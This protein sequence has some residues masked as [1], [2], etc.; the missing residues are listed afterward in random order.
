MAT[1][2]SA[3]S[4][5]ALLDEPD[6]SLQVYSLEN[7]NQ[8]ADEFW[9]EIADYVTKIEELYEDDKFPQ[10]KLTA[11]VASKVGF[12]GRPDMHALASELFELTFPNRNQVYYNLAE[13]DQSMHFALAAGELFDLSVKTEYVETIVCMCATV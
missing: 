5:L 1:L 13:F 2:T 7:L 4:L 12:F 8:L 9:A 10:S 6:Q 3:T 11:L